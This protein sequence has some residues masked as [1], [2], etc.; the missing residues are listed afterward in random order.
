MKKQ[1]FIISIVAI[2]VSIF[3]S[4]SANSNMEDVSAIVVTDSNGTTHYY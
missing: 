2:L 4:R 3:V 1:L